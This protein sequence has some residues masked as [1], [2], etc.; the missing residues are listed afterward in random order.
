MAAHLDEARTTGT[1]ALPA[2]LRLN[3]NDEPA[4]PVRGPNAK[5]GVRDLVIVANR[6]P[7]H[8]AA[9]GGCCD[10]LPVAGAAH[11]RVHERA[12]VEHL[13]AATAAALMR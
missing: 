2:I 11:R 6:L 10:K 8:P 7:V 1:D 5:C 4:V 12:D 13:P 9:I 3:G